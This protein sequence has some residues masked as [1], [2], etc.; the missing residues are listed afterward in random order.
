MDVAMLCAHGQISPVET[1][2][3]TLSKNKSHAQTWF[4]LSCVQYL[5]RHN[6]RGS[7]SLHLLKITSTFENLSCNKRSSLSRSNPWIKLVEWRA[8]PNLISSIRRGRATLDLISSK[9]SSGHGA[10]VRLLFKLKL[11]NVSDVRLLKLQGNLQY[12]PSSNLSNIIPFPFSKGSHHQFRRSLS[13][14]QTNQAQQALSNSQFGRYAN[15]SCWINWS[16]WCGNTW[17]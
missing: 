12:S 11:Q 14:A 8:G 3:A 7:E 4:Q 6:R 17:T 10:F 1:L 15:G 5:T 13:I 2:D 16:A 9:L